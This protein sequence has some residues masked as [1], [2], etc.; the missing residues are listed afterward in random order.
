MIIFH[1]F[2]IGTAILFC[3]GFAAWAWMAFRRDAG[4]DNLVLAV[5]FA[6]A[7]LALAYYLKNLKR[8][9]GRR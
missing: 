1:R 9:L 3:A 6:L 4:T 7:A 2:L 8:F 5:A